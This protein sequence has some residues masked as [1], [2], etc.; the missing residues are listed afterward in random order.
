LTAVRAPSTDRRTGILAGASAYLIWGLFP[1]YYHRLK[2]VPA[3]ELACLRILLTSASVWFVLLVRRDRSWFRDLISDR[4]R[5]AM[6]ALAGLMVTTNW[7][8][9]VWAAAHGHVV[10]AAIGYFINPLIS[11]ALGVFFLHERL[12]RNQKIALAFGFASVCVLT[13]TYGTIP[14]VALSLASSF[15]L[16]GFLKK[17]TALDGVRALAAETFT[18]L[19]I[20]I[21]GLA[22]VASRSSGLA[23][24]KVSGSTLI[25]TLLV[26]IITAVPLSLFGIAAT[27]IP[28]ALLGLLQYITPVG[29]LLCGVLLLNEPVSAARWTGIALV[30]IALVILAA[31]LLTELRRQTEPVA[32]L[33]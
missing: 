7:L 27:R 29:Q 12:R 14:W 23:V 25:L 31:D 6:V 22:V 4:R 19:P 8:I 15:G 11:V 13:I 2:A 26:G 21:I 32:Q 9:Y 33:A 17:T 28:L 16:Y 3:F 18:M 1:L 30:A 24:A 5:L 20:G 10:D